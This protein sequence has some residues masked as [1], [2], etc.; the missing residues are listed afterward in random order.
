MRFAFPDRSLPARP[1][2]LIAKP[3]CPNRRYELCTCPMRWENCK[4]TGYPS[5]TPVWL[6]TWLLIIADNALH[7]AI[8]FLALKY[9]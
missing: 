8:N 7:L 6:A 3:D 2:R 5:E 9:L 1:V 4:A